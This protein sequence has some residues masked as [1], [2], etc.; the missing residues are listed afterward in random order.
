MPY[1]QH[2]P[3]CILYKQ[4]KRYGGDPPVCRRRVARYP[5]YLTAEEVVVDVD[6]DVIVITVNNNGYA[7]AN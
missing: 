4:C 5:P 3:I 6:N 7:A 2:L 1:P